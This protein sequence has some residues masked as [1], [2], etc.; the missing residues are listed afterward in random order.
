MVSLPPPRSKNKPLL[1]LLEPPLPHRPLNRIHHLHNPRRLQPL[2]Q[3]KQ[4]LRLP[5][6]LL[7]RHL[8][9]LIPRLH[10]PPLSRNRVD[11]LPIHRRRDFFAE[12]FCCSAIARIVVVVEGVRGH[13]D[14]VRH[15]IAR[16]EAVADVADKGCGV[17]VGELEE[18]AGDGFADG[19]GGRG[20]GEAEEEGGEGGGGAE[21]VGALGVGG[22]EGGAQV[23]CE[24]G[25]GVGVEFADEGDEG[26]CEGFEVFVF[27]GA[28]SE[29]EDLD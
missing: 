10:V 23:G 14:V 29:V 15:E 28:D 1:H 22:E 3:H 19:G 21:G 27:V 4:L 24:R 17:G 6:L 25:W 9:P 7:I 26:G 16:G 2:K 20:G 18:Q 12:I 13:G 8:R 5:L 11:L